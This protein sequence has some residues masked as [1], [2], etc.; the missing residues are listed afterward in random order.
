MKR[1]VTVM[2]EDCACLLKRYA[3]LWQM[4]QS[5]VLFEAAMSHIHGQAHSGC[6]ATINLL[7]DHKIKLDKRA[8]KHCY[9]YPCRVCKHDK[10]C[11]VGKHEGHWECDDRYK[12]LLTPE[13]PS[14]DPRT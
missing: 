12:H 3:A 11:R 13:N 9:G 1:V 14:E 4:T 5:E 6:T 10:A 2:T 7:D 8:S